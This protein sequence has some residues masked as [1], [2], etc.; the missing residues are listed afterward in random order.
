MMFN[1]KTLFL[2]IILS[3][4]GCK[5][6]KNPGTGQDTALDTAKIERKE[7][8]RPEVPV[9]LTD[10]GQQ[11]DFLVRHY[12]DH[13]DFADTTY[14]SF[15]EITEQAWVDYIDMLRHIPLDKAQKEMG[16][17][18]LKSVQ[19]SK[20]L[21]LYFTEM[22][23]KYL[24]DPNSPMRNEELYMPVLEAMIQTPA[25]S[26]TEKMLS[27]HRLEWAYKNRVGTKATD[28]QYADI[29]GKTGTLYQVKAE[30]L[31]VFF[32]NP[33]CSSCMEHIESISRSPVINQFLLE[34]RLRILSVYS[35]Q[36]LEEWKAH[37][38]DYPVGWING[39]DKPLT[40]ETK[41]DLK[42]IPTLYLLDKN[43]RVLLKDAPIIQIE[44]YLRYF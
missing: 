24:Y 13:F 34:N 42:A 28:F 23:D 7:F 38:A 4:F 20:K 40:I 39:Y 1:K 8:I 18:M 10:P 22:A 44:N 12:W 33:G 6:N 3:A 15:P 11:L 30:Y 41:Y 2:F 27:K 14:V 29:Q 9:M 26:D 25:L 17:M 36:E 19:N 21:F 35:G 43:K 5:N 32:N 37:Y 31:I 16:A